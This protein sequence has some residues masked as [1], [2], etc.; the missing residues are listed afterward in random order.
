MDA[1]QCIDA[2]KPVCPCKANT[3]GTPINRQST[4]LS[5]SL[6][7]AA[8]TVSGPVPAQS[9]RLLPERQS[10]T[11]ARTDPRP[12]IPSTMLYSHP[13]ENQASSVAPS[14]VATSLSSDDGAFVTCS[15]MS[16]SADTRVNHRPKSRVRESAQSSLPNSS[17]PSSS[18][19]S[20]TMPPPPVPRRATPQGPT[21]TDDER[22][23][24]LA[25]F[26]QHPSLYELS[27]TDLETLVSQVI[28][29]EG[30]LH[31]VHENTPR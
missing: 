30:F 18:D 27:R 7:R 1:S 3:Q 31:L 10:I 21:G 2:I 8:T 12:I 17:Q 24:L 29:E 14:S 11:P 22:S 20:V 9:A 5:S 19:L 15:E 26:S 23:Q 25:S 13:P 4:M 6:T 28:R 16:Q